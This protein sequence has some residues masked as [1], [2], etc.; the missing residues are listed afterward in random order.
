MPAKT[1]LRT[2]TAAQNAGKGRFAIYGGDATNGALKTMY[3]GIRPTLGSYVP[4]KK[5][6]SIILGTGGDNS[7]TS[8]G[9]WFEGVMASGAA[10][11]T[12]I[13][14]VQANIVAAGYGK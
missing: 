5:Q 10:T 9:H 7:D 8:E 12:T 4:M 1:R 13:N 11:T 3:D 2:P 6:G 14:A